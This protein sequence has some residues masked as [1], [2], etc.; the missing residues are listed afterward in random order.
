M[1]DIIFNP[2][3]QQVELLKSNKR[4]KGAFAGRRGGKTEYGAVQSIL[5]QEQKP[6]DT[7]SN[8]DPY[9]GVI[10]APTFDMLRRLSLKKFM[11]YAG[12]FIKSFNKS[13]CEITW[14]DG[15]IIYGLSADKPERIEGLKINWGWL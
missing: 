15:S 11:A 12:P 2:F 7:K 3:K 14:H 9:L 13:T 8:I 1:D 4:I 6:N 10:I 5:Y